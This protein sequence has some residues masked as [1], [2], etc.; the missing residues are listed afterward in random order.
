M[1]L[2]LCL[3]GYG[4]MGK[5][6]A[7]LANDYD[8]KV[9][10]IIDPRQD[11]CH[12][13]ISLQTIGEAEVC[14]DFSHPSVILNNIQKVLFCQKN[15]VVGT[16][17]WFQ[18]L[19]EVQKL[20]E[21]AGTGFLYG[22]NFSIGMNIFNR[23]VAEAT[24]AFDRFSDYDV[25]GLEMHHNQK[26]D[27]PSGTAIELSKT[28]LANSQRKKKVLFDPAYRKIEPEELHFASLRAGSFPGTH[29]VGFD[30]EA[31]TIE[32][33][34]C[35]RSRST[36]AKGALQA[37]KWINVRKGIFTFNDMIADILC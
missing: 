36:F 13:D 14:I 33:S 5:M 2:K 31:E 15:L 29:K 12:S 34:H 24:K 19:A 26:A 7:D 28:I 1:E 16:T 3:I 23:L 4:K 17:G 32:L 9:V 6:I 21:Q 10:S 27:S 18:N 25:Y 11:N 37:A 22:A 35:V 20:V 30:S 8:C